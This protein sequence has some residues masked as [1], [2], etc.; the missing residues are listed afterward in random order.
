MQLTVIISDQDEGSAGLF[1][2]GI[3]IICN[4]RAKT[5][6][7]NKDLIKLQHIIIN[8]GKVLKY[9]LA[10]RREAEVLDCV[11]HICAAG[12]CIKWKCK[13]GSIKCL[14][15]YVIK[16]FQDLTCYLSIAKNNGCAGRQSSLLNFSIKGNS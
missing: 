15:L 9:R 11:H 1:L 14:M 8:N 16:T 10:A 5:K 13:R 6:F 2:S 7:C 12:L 4:L 3:P